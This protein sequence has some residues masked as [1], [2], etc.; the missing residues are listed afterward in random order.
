MDFATAWEWAGPRFKERILAEGVPGQASVVLGKDRVQE[1]APYIGIAAL[2]HSV[3][4]ERFVR[5]AIGKVFFPV[6][7]EQ[8]GKRAVD[9]AV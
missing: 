1:L 3:Q 2:H 5:A 4:A 7:E 6:P 9:R 8:S